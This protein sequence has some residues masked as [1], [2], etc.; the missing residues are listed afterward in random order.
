M[1]GRST[2][3]S[4]LN[5]KRICTEAWR[6]YTFAGGE[7]VRIEEPLELHV[8]ANGHRILDGDGVSHYVPLTW[9][10]LK[11]KVKDGEP[12]FSF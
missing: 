12:S 4:G 8:S 2:A 7:V 10:H 1:G 9:V 11:W 5:F 6:E 3:A